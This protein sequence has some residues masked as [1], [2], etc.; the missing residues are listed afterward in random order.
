MVCFVLC[1][2]KLLKV[3]GVYYI[4][5]RQSSLN[6]QVNSVALNL[7]KNDVT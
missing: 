3:E 4:K 6:T 2:K 1:I 7:Y 5:T